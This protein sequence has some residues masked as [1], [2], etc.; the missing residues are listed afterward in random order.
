[1]ALSGRDMRQIFQT[2]TC[3]LDRGVK[4]PPESFTDE[5]KKCYNDFEKEILENKAAGRIVNYDFPNDYDW[6]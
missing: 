1:M 4:G 6:D 3:R 2:V 5:E